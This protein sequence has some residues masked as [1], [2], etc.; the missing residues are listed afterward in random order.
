LKVK[1]VLES[2]HLMSF[3]YWIQEWRICC[4]V[5]LSF[6]PL[7]DCWKVVKEIESFL[8][9]FGGGFEQYIDEQD[10]KKKRSREDDE[11]SNRFVV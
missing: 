9:K 10:K 5:D 2:R 1:V 7:V 6:D 8:E 11:E 3:V 4:E